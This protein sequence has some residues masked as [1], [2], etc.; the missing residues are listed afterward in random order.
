MTLLTHTEFI[1]KHYL[2]GKKSGSSPVNTQL[3][4][5]SLY[6]SSDF[7]LKKKPVKISDEPVA[8]VIYSKMINNVLL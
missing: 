6:F 8:I 3:W 4:Q 5:F 7:E 1:M 2:I